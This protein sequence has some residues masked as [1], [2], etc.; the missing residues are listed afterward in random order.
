LTFRRSSLVRRTGRGGLAKDTG[1]YLWS[2]TVPSRPTYGTDMRFHRSGTDPVALVNGAVGLWENR[3]MTNENE[4]T[5]SLE[6]LTLANTVQEI[7]THVAQGGWDGPTRVFAIIRTKEALA[8]TP[9][10]ATQMP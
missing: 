4:R 1:F 8:T 3:A 10:L 9:K 2:G 5:Y 6:E 7:E